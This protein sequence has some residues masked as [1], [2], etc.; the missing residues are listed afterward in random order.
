MAG[1]GRLCPYYSKKPPSAEVVFAENA[2]FFTK[3][4]ELPK[5]R[6][7]TAKNPYGLP[8]AAA[9]YTSSARTRRPSYS[10]SRT[11]TISPLA[12]PGAATAT[13]TYSRV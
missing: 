4:A 8:D 2:N 6:V 7:Y 13:G 9:A 1:A 5:N 11:R 10:P 12:W 3:T